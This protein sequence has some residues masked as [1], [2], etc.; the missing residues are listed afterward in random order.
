MVIIPFELTPQSLLSDPEWL[1]SHD[2]PPPET[3]EID[4]DNISGYDRQVIE[5]LMGLKPVSEE[6]AVSYTHLTLPT[7]VRV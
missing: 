3:N 4:T 2:T 1:A 7:T 6:M 5:E